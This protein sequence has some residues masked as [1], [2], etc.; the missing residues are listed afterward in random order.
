MTFFI[1]CIVKTPD[2]AKGSIKKKRDKTGMKKEFDKMS[3]EE[4]NG[5][6][7]EEMAAYMNE[8]MEGTF[9]G[10]LGMKV[11]KYSPGYCLTEFEI[12]T[13]YLNPMG[14][15]HGGLMFT[16]ADNTAGIASHDMSQEGIVTTIN[17]GLQFL[18]P[19]LNKTKLY[20]E[21]NVLKNGKRIVYTDVMI[22]DETT[23]YAKGTYTFA[24]IILKK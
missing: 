15:V 4:V 2:S 20:A 7:P 6:T 13:E 16:I 12:K 10:F 3:T 5:K 8:R 24:R 11:L 1:G 19:A 21:A 23:I 17:G 18:N 14:G 9:G 22:K